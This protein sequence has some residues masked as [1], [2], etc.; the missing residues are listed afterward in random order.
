MDTQNQAAPEDAAVQRSDGVKPMTMDEA[1]TEMVVESVHT[2]GDR[3]PEANTATVSDEP[4]EG[5]VE[6]KKRKID[7]T[8]PA[9]P[10]TSKTHS[11]ADIE[12][13]FLNGRLRYGMTP[14]GPGLIVEMVDSDVCPI[15]GTPQQQPKKADKTETTTTTTASS[16]TKEHP[17]QKQPQLSVE[18]Q[19]AME[20]MGRLFDLGGGHHRH[21]KA[22][23]LVISG[24][25]LKASLVVHMVKAQST[26][27]LQ[28][29][30][31]LFADTAF[32]NNKML[33]IYPL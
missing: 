7:A 23:P 20:L 9:I 3:K 1:W 16:T 27:G 4:D 30:H 6:P 26:S 28:A 21:N 13:A 29:L 15:H 33:T 17:Q 31:T 10:Q 12:Q 8:Q 18:E 32:D 19:R 2:M 11:V 5:G 22:Q 25:D 14:F 24:N